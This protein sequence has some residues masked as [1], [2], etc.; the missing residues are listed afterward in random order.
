MGARAE[1]YGQDPLRSNPQTCCPERPVSENPIRSSYPHQL[2]DAEEPVLQALG[3]GADVM[4]H[5]LVGFLLGRSLQRLL[6]RLLPTG[7]GVV[8]LNSYPEHLGLLAEVLLVHNSIL[9]NDEG[10][11]TG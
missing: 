2:E 9:V 7:V 6:F 10:H 8:L 3:N 5:Q 11:H 1:I 4:T